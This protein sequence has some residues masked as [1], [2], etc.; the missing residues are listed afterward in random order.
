MCVSTGNRYLE[1]GLA[2]AIGA[3]TGVLGAPGALGIAVYHGTYLSSV[4]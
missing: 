4:C 1:I 3:A 2:V